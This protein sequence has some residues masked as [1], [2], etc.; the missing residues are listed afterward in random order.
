[1]PSES[2]EL[3]GS[4]VA[5]RPFSLKAAGRERAT[6]RSVP[7][8]APVRHSGRRAADRRHGRPGLPTVKRRWRPTASGHGPGLPAAPSLA[9]ALGPAS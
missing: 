1:M 7:S 9:P 8:E 5:S 2:A 6:R 3:P 4:K